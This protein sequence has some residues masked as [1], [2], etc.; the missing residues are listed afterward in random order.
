MDEDAEHS[1]VHTPV[2][3]FDN[4][5]E[6]TA[7]KVFPDGRRMAVTSSDGILRV[8]DLKNGVVL[9]ELEM[10]GG[11]MR[12]MALSQDGKL[13]VGCT[14]GYV[15]AWDGDTGKRL[16]HAFSPHEK[17]ALTALDI[18]PDGAT[19]ATAGLMDGIRL[20]STATWQ[21]QGE[22]IRVDCRGPVCNLRY[23]PSGG[24]LSFTT[25]S[26][27]QIWN[28]VTREHITTIDRGSGSLA[29]TPDGT[30]FLS[31]LY[32]IIQEWDTSTW[33]KVGDTIW[34]GPDLFCDIAM[35]CDGTVVAFP[36]TGN[37]LRLWHL[38]DR[39][40]IA[41]FQHSKF[42][43]HITFSVDGKHIFAGCSKDNKVS[44]WAVPEHAWPE[45]TAKDQATDQVC[46]CSFH[47]IRYLIFLVSGLL[48]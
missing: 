45:D 19:L 2:W 46:L 32:N 26:N 38:L 16:I 1:I 44:V 7:V 42:P 8:W 29:W 33:T 10:R 23:S 34:R 9:R 5:G 35:N 13:I 27:I 48:C 21:P 39:R 12:D 28:P 11:E 41:I 4:F 3:V 20:W 17:S 36:T 15:S 18:S 47:F 43:R 6:V 14:G 31:V 22:P 40:T 24:L 37:R 30:R 25:N